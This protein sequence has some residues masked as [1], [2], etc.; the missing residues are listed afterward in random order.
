MWYLNRQV[1]GVPPAVPA[2]VF[3]VSLGHQAAAAELGLGS[4]GRV[5]WNFYLGASGD[6]GRW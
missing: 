3:L 4:L 1:P 2:A 6:S 5:P